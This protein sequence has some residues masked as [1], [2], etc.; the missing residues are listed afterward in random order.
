MKQLV[1][2]Q[3]YIMLKLIIAILYNYCVVNTSD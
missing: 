3:R 2:N 1:N